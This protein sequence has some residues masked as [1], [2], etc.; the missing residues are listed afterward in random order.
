VRAA[1]VIDDVLATDDNALANLRRLS[2]EK[3]LKV[4]VLQPRG[5]VEGR[6]DFGGLPV[7]TCAEGKA[8]CWGEEPTLLLDASRRAGATPSESFLVCSS[9]EDAARGANAGCRPIIVLAGRTLDDVYGPAEPGAKE[10]ACAPDLSTAVG[11]ILDETEQSE[12]LG[13]FPYAPVA[14]LEERARTEAPS[15]AELT[16]LMGIVVAAGIAVSLGIAYLLQEVYQNYR[17]PAVFYYLTLQ[18]IPQALR[19]ALFLLLGAGAA[20]VALLTLN[21]LPFR[22]RR[23]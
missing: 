3:S 14:T 19:G 1:F 5:A 18:P 22:R 9:L 11:Y 4:V 10:A 17:F 13:A 6:H 16:R 20:V 12:A 8:D 2:D 15:R 21:R 7:V 23:T